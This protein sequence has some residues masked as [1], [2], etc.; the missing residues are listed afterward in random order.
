MHVWYVHGK[1]D[2]VRGQLVGLSYFSIYLVYLS[3]I[4]Y[5]SECADMPHLQLLE[6]LAVLHIMIVGILSHSAL[7]TYTGPKDKS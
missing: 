3:V 5:S 6:F 2:L 1:H 4:A 7:L